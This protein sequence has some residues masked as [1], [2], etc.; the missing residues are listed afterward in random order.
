M[1]EEQYINFEDKIVMVGDEILPIVYWSQGE[2][3]ECELKDAWGC[4]AGPNKEGQFLC[5]NLMDLPKP[6]AVN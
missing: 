2:N 1:S 6:E 5:F 3:T 4:V